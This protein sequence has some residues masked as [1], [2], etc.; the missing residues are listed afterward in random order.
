MVC[1]LG[2]LRLWALGG[3]LYDVVNRKYRRGISR[4]REG[5]FAGALGHGVG[6]R[7]LAYFPLAASRG[8]ERYRRS[9]GVD[10]FRVDIQV[11]E[12]L[13]GPDDC[14]DFD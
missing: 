13:G 6:L 8:G 9:G 2:G 12:E 1:S 14:V 7:S 4:F 10:D 11:Y 5:I 3:V